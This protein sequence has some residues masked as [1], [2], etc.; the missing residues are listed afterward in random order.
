MGFQMLFGFPERFVETAQRRA[1]IAGDEA[2]R[3]ESRGQ[4]APAL[5]QREAH[6]RL[7]AGQVNAVL[8]GGVF[9][10]EGNLPHV[11]LL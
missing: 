1:A 2:G 6:Q 7:D 10:F 5:D 8:V 11:R 4:V 9:V 3:V